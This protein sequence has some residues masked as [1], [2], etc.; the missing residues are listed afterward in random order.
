[1]DTEIFTAY[2]GSCLFYIIWNFIYIAWFWALVVINFVPQHCF[3]P[4]YLWTLILWLYSKLFLT[5]HVFVPKFI[6]PNNFIWTHQLFFWLNFFPDPVFFLCQQ[7]L[8]PKFILDWIFFNSKFFGTKIFLHLK[9]CLDH[10]FLFD[11]KYFL[12]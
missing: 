2:A 5:Q 6:G 8:R 4:K 7:F 9:I 1:M 11:P 12:I 3:G 10:F